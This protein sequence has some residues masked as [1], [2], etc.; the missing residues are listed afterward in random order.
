MGQ[1]QDA[2]FLTLRIKVDQRHLF[3]R[4]SGKRHRNLEAVLVETFDIAMMVGWA[5]AIAAASY[6][7]LLLLGSWWRGLTMSGAAVG[8]LTG[9]LLSLCAIVGSMLLD[10]VGN[11]DMIA[12][13][14]VVMVLVLAVLL[15][16]F[17][18]D[19]LYTVIDP[20][21]RAAS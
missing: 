8:M 16:N 11:R 18:V 17:V 14:G 9:G 6:F 19:L 3:R 4:E 5:F 13:Q 7:P 2:F 1:I 21:L 20:R 15:I 10:S 12:V